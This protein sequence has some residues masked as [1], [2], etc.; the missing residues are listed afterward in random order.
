MRTFTFLPENVTVVFSSNG[1]V[2]CRG[3]FPVFPYNCICNP[4]TAQWTALPEPLHHVTDSV[5]L[6]FRPS[7]LNFSVDI[8][9]S[10]FSLSRQ[11]KLL[12][13]VD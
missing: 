8:L 2:A 6:V 5:A 9:G 10:V 7:P 13:Q 11:L 12:S 4:A 1:L 3:L